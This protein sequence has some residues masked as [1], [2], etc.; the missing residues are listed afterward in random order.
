MSS[1]PAAGPGRSDLGLVAFGAESPCLKG[2][3]N[4][5][6]EAPDGPVVAS[7][8]ATHWVLFQRQ[9]RHVRPIFRRVDGPMLDVWPVPG[10]GKI[11][12]GATLRRWEV[13]RPR[14]QARGEVSQ[15]PKAS[16]AL[17]PEASPHTTGRP[18]VLVPM[19]PV[20]GSAFLRRK[21]SR[22]VI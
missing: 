19:V 4:M 18:A 13:C 17:N 9:R 14:L 11:I 21:V 8:G 1:R 20:S 15:D 6:W 16:R 22:Y 12:T 7:A 5:A 3:S 2:T 10:P